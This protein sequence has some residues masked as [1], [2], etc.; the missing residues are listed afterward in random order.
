MHV[1]YRSYSEK[2]ITKPMSFERYGSFMDKFEIEEIYIAIKNKF[3]TNQILLQVR[4]LIKK[5]S[6]LKNKNKQ[7]M[8]HMMKNRNIWII[9]MSHLLNSMQ[10]KPKN[11]SAYLEQVD[12]RCSNPECDKMAHKTCSRCIV[13]RYCSVECQGY[14]W[15]NHKNICKRCN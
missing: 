11:I 8:K 7:E 10:K 14:D 6:N 9:Y 15:V 3:N 2:Y 1:V 4:T 13:I 12:D 5:Y